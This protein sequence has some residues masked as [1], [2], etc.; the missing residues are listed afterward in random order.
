M[1][2]TKLLRYYMEIL[3]YK[4]LNGVGQKD[5]KTERV[6]VHRNDISELRARRWILEN[7]WR[8]NLCVLDIL[9]VKTKTV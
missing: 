1:K 3:V 6:A 7:A 4:N 5:R 2:R 8:Q 9:L